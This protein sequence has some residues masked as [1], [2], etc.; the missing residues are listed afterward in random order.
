MIGWLE[1]PGKADPT[2]GWVVESLMKPN[3]SMNAAHVPEPF[4][5]CLGGNV[6]CLYTW[7]MIGYN[8]KEPL[9]SITYWEILVNIFT[10]LQYNILYYIVL[11]FNVVY[12]TVL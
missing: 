9:S 2:G 12:C 10:T 1:S 4:D 7:N 5:C 3:I 11:Y 8:S 6:E